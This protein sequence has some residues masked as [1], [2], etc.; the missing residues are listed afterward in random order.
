MERVRSRTRERKA[1]THNVAKPSRGKVLM[2]ALN[3]VLEF[4]PVARLERRRVAVDERQHALQPPLGVLVLV[5]APGVVVD[6]G[7]DEG[8]QRELDAVGLGGHPSEV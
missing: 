3:L 6:P 2:V 5:L 8:L 1:E 4:L 7:L